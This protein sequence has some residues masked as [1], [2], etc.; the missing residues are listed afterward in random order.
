MKEEYDITLTQRENGII[1][2]PIDKRW[3]RGEEYGFLARHYNTY[4]KLGIFKVYD[5]SQP[6]E[7][8]ENPRR[9]NFIIFV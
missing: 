5:K 4:S 6:L 1:D 2:F 7:V 9:I 8:Y 3:L